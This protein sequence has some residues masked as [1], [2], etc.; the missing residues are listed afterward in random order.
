L[1]CVLNQRKHVRAAPLDKTCTIIK[2]IW[3]LVL[4]KG[5]FGEFNEKLMLKNDGAAPPAISRS[6]HLA[7]FLQSGEL[8]IYTKYKMVLK[9]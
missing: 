8:G 2:H 5:C 1:K 4:W 9:T 7:S 3:Y 6:P